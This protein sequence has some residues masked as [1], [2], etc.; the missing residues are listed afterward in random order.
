MVL[1]RATKSPHSAKTHGT[2]NKDMGLLAQGADSGLGPQ[3]LFPD[4]AQLC[5][6]TKKEVVMATWLCCIQGRLGLT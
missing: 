1:C 3:P 5:A 2:S 6:V 4:S